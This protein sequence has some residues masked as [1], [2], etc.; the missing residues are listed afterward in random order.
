MAKQAA[1][2]LLNNVVN[3]IKNLPTKIRTIITNAYNRI[4]SG[5][6]NWVVT[7]KKKAKQTMDGAVNA[8]RN[9]PSNIGKKITSTAKNIASNAKAWVTNAKEKAESMRKAVVDKV[10]NLVTD[11]VNEFASLPGKIR[12][13]IGDAV[14]A[15]KNAIAKMPAAVKKVLGIAS[16]GFIQRAIVAEF[17]DTVTRIADTASKAT[18][19]AKKVAHGIRDGFGSVDLDT[20]LDTYYGDIKDKEYIVN[21]KEEQEL[22]VNVK[23]EHDYQFTGLPDSVSAKEVASMI[24]E[25]NKND[26]WVKQL[27]S[28]PRF[29]HFDLKEK[30]RLTRKNKRILG[31]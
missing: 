24:N 14:N 6:D 28:N 18:S 27:T 17:T 1:S 22:T 3:G 23:H 13:A 7:A 15:A 16:P 29:Q 20:S 9:L 26:D 11:V 2:K 8:L 5:M 10:S 21:S 31:V 4:K 25:A 12:K 19:A 30:T